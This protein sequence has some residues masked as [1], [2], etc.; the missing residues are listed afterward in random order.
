MRCDEIDTRGRM[1]PVSLVKVARTCE[2]GGQF[3]DLAV[4]ALPISSRCISITT[5]PLGPKRWELAHLIAAFAKV[6]WFRNQF[7]LRNNWILINDIKERRES[8]D[9]MEF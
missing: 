9:F 7:H 6:P 2:T 5:V 3:G 4:I 1:T 8:V